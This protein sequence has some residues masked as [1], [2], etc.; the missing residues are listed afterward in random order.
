MRVGI[1]GAGAAACGAAAQLSVMG[2]E[3]ILWSPSGRSTEAL[4]AGAPLRATGAIEASFHPH[5][6]ANAAEA[7]VGTDAVMLAMP[8]A[9]C[10]SST[11][12]KLIRSIN[13]CTTA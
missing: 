4:A 13:C 3:P 10:L 7:V 8:I 12:P 11:I 9:V 6:A 5:I 2:H 1:L